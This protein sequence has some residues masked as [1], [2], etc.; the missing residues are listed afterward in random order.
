[1]LNCREATRLLSENQD[2]TL[3]LHEKMGLRFHVLICSGCRHCR[4]QMS[5]L[6]LAARMY[7]NGDNENRD[8]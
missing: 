6:R 8:E 4:K 7:V 5:S 2:R 1:M 3:T